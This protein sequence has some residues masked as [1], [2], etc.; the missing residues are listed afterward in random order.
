[1]LAR[2][3][4]DFYCMVMRDWLI[5]RALERLPVRRSQAS[6]LIYLA[7]LNGAFR[8]L[9]MWIT[10]VGLRPFLLVPRHFPPS[11][12]LFFHSFELPELPCIVNFSNFADGRL[13]AMLVCNPKYWLARSARSSSPKILPKSKCHLLSSPALTDKPRT[14]GYHEETNP[15]PTSLRPADIASVAA[16]QDLRPHHLRSRPPPFPVPASSFPLSTYRA[17]SPTY[18]QIVNDDPV[19]QKSKLPSSACEN[20]SILGPVAICNACLRVS[21]SSFVNSESR[22]C[23]EC[24]PKLFERSKKDHS[25]GQRCLLP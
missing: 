13:M 15:R 18:Q 1:M 5:R 14:N 3:S 21:D 6:L 12:D 11:S 23:I 25:K 9:H 4:L 2:I 8:V 17:L 19:F 16:H 10:S 7:K 22:E 20:K 24:S